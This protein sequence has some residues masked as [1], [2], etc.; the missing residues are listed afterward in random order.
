MPDPSGLTDDDLKAALLVHGVKAGP[1]VGEVALN[2]VFNLAFIVEMGFLSSLM[3]FCVLLNVL[4]RTFTPPSLYFVLQ[5]N[6][7]RFIYP[8]ASL[9]Q[10]LV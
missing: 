5:T 10:G 3:T 7:N 8:Y 6:S 4:R 1:I 9:H 2:T